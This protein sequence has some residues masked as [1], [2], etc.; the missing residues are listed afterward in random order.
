M[1]NR[2]D[3]STW[4]LTNSNLFLFDLP[5]L[6]LPATG[7]TKPSTWPIGDE[8][9]AMTGDAAAGLNGDPLAGER[10][11]LRKRSISLAAGLSGS[12]RCFR[13]D[14]AALPELKVRDDRRSGCGGG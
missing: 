8:D 5:D 9:E 4:N 11:G 6:A 12:I 1:I 7:Q 14:L 2:T 3:Q 10:L 13:T